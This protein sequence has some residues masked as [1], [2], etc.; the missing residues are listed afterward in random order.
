M[1]NQYYEQMYRGAGRQC[2]GGGWGPG[3]PKEAGFSDNSEPLKSI[4]EKS[5]FY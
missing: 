5:G 2:W 4:G 1:K 3:G